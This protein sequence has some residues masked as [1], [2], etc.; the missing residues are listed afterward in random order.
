MESQQQEAEEPEAE[1]D[2]A[3]EKPYRV[4]ATEQLPWAVSELGVP[5]HSPRPFYP[6]SDFRI[7]NALAASSSLAFPSYVHLSS[8]YYNPQWWREPRRLKN[9]IILMEW[10]PHPS[11]PLW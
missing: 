11:C 6:L 9:V 1:A 10:A 2:E 4:D 8:N 3:D 5:P 7:F